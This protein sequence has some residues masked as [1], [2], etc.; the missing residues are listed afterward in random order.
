SAGEVIAQG[1][2][3]AVQ[4]GHR[5]LGA[6]GSAPSAQFNLAPLPHHERLGVPRNPGPLTRRGGDDVA[7]PRRGGH[8]RLMADT[9]RLLDRRAQLLVSPHKREDPSNPG[10]VDPL[11]FGKSLDLFEFVDVPQ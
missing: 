1:G 11:F 7:R 10:E 5:A 9:E 6:A 2:A 3:P 8:A 4:W